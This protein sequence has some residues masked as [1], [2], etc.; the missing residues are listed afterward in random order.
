MRL[1]TF[2]LK[3]EPVVKAGLFSAD[4][5]ALDLVAAAAALDPAMCSPRYQIL[6]RAP[7]E[8][9]WLTAEGL[10][11]IRALH[12]RTPADSPVW[13]SWSQITLGPPVRRPG[14]I[15]AVG[16]NY[17][18][19]VRESEKL[20]A[21]RG[22]KVDVPKFPSAFAKFSSTLCAAGAPILIPRDVEA[23]DYEVELAVV[24]GKPAHD[25]VESEAL[26]FVAGYT[27]CN[28]VGARRIQMA[29]MEQQIGIVLAKN[30]RNFAPLGP[31][32]VTT[33]EIPDPQ[34]LT[35]G[36]TVNGETRQAAH[37]GDMIFSVAKLVSYWSQIGLEVGDIIFT[38][39][40]AGVAIG[41]AEPEKSYLR[42][43]D[44]VC[45][46]I[47]KIGSLDNPVQAL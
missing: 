46:T 6:S 31:W 16:R 39:T 15:V 35:I 27:I 17:L 26:E 14:K 8:H 7:Y 44:L 3:G 47:E 2:S 32:L 5:R 40:P 36:L 37:T 10:S 28:D 4:N 1:G 24:I 25:V 29:E 23:V 11:A 34:T 21:A 9:R 22:R 12:E 19:H 45:A 13:F 20:W 43:G 30:F 33:D 38:G 18:D 42:D 41:R